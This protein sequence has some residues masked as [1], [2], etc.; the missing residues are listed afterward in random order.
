MESYV[1]DN[2]LAKKCFRGY[3]GI[4]LSVRPSVCLSVCPSMYKIL[5]SVKALT[6]Y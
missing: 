3:A 2:T 4:S 1:S 5:V 6:G